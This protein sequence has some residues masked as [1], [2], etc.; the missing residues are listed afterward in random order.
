M[1]V[2]TAEE[3]E[4]K[5]LLVGE[6]NYHLLWECGE[7]MRVEKDTV[8]MYPARY[9]IR[10]DDP[11]CICQG[12][13]TDDSSATTKK[14]EFGGYLG[15]G[16][17]FLHND[18]SKIME[19]FLDFLENSFR[20]ETDVLFFLDVD[21]EHYDVLCDV[22]KA[23]LY[24]CVTNYTPV[25]DLRRSEADLWNGLKDGTRRAVQ[26]AEK[27]GAHFV[28]NT[29]E[30]GVEWFCELMKAYD[31]GIISDPQVLRTML[32]TG[33]KAS[34]VNLFF[35]VVGPTVAAGAAILSCKDVIAYTL[36][37]MK[38][39]YSTYRPSNL[40]HWEIMKWAKK[41]GYTLYNMVWA[42][43]PGYPGHSIAQFKLGFGAHL[44]EVPIYFRRFKR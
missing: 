19:T 20:T 18:H 5:S 38:R 14:I 29:S 13:V 33:I 15:E 11:V 4:W 23:H 32:H 9:C 3:P 12:I 10:D 24:T 43:P 30:E 26:Q 34:V 42:P 25:I 44:K 21:R 2:V 40:L 1:D 31:L 8:S 37:G 6:Y 17:L 35:T 39:E 16:M 22:L 41:S 36:G 7:I 28:E 27:R